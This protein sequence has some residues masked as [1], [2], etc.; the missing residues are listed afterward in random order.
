MEIF[1]FV[2]RRLHFR[3]K[4]RFLFSLT[5]TLVKRNFRH[6]SF[7]LAMTFCK[8]RKT[9]PVGSAVLKFIWHKQKDINFSIFKQYPCRVL[10][11]SLNSALW[12]GI[13]VFLNS[14]YCVVCCRSIGNTRFTTV[15]LKAL[16]YEILIRCQCSFVFSFA[17]SSRKWIANFLFIRSNGK[18]SNIN[19]FCVGIFHIYYQIKV[20][21]VQ[22]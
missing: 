1:H 8:H 17:V 6:F 2:K 16:P 3:E 9:S 11:K 21:K 5:F 19:T 10:L 12:C 13:L 7:V 4:V 18:L 20:L 22:L 15:P 14:A